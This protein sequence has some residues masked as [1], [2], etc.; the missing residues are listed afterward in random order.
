MKYNRNQANSTILSSYLLEHARIHLEDFNDSLVWMKLIQQRLHGSEVKY[1]H[2]ILTFSLHGI[3]RVFTVNGQLISSFQ[4]I[5]GIFEN[6]KVFY[7][8]TFGE[9][10]L[11]KRTCHFH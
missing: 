9:F 5:D 8:G 10:L 6:M 11:F 4:L 7:D 3:M 1:I 2:M